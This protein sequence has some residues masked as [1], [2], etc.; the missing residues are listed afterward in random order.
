[1]RFLGGAALEQLV[2][3]S[4]DALGAGKLHSCKLGLVVFP[5]EVLHEADERGSRNA[6][7]LFLDKL[8]VA[9]VEH[10]LQRTEAVDELVADVVRVPAGIG[11]V[12]EY[13]QYLMF[14]EAVD[15]MLQVF[16][17]HAL[18]VPGM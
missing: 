14:L 4:A 2:A 17:Q 16:F 15:A 11:C 3:E 6:D 9:R 18:S 8:V 1:M 13:F 5:R 10:T 7:V 12:E